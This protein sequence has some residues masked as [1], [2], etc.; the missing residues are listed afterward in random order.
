MEYLIVFIILSLF[1]IELSS[2]KK[3]TIVDEKIQ[4]LYRIRESIY[5]DIMDG[6]TSLNEDATK[7]LVLTIHCLIYNIENWSFITFNELLRKAAEKEK[8]EEGNNHPIDRSWVESEM[9]D[10]YLWDIIDAW[11]E[12]IAVK[13]TIMGFIK[14]LVDTDI[15]EDRS[16]DV[17][18][19]VTT[20]VSDEELSNEYFMLS[21]A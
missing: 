6:K 1:F 12:C 15:I 4:K 13:S 5:D 19:K 21:A 10:K 8:I 2:R 16:E 3:Q 18:E 7:Y 11:L 17:S 9:A 14:Y 20:I